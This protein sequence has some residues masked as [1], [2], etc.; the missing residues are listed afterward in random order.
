MMWAVIKT[1]IENG[2]ALFN[3]KGRAANKKIMASI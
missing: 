3:I 2:N 1:M